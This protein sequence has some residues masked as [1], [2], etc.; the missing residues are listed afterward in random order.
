[1]SERYKR[2]FKWTS[3]ISNV[4]FLDVVGGTFDKNNVKEDRDSGFICINSRNMSDEINDPYVFPK[5]FNQV[6]FYPYVLDED[7]WFILRQKHKS[8][9]VF[10]N[11]NVNMPTKE[12]NEGDGNEEW[13]VHVLFH[14][15]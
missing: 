13:Y 2:S 7:W 12:D 14:H 4:L 10:K 3:H 8:K 11:N 5:H 1:M 6:L 15:L 9:H